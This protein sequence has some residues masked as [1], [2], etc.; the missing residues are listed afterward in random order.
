MKPEQFERLPL[1]ARQE[2]TKLRADLEYL[3][4]RMREMT[5]GDEVGR[6][7]LIYF[8]DVDGTQL[9]PSGTHVRFT[10]GEESPSDYVDVYLDRMDPRLLE[11]H[12]GRRFIIE[13]GSANMFGVR[14]MGF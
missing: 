11:V 8:P 12:G 6:V 10:L 7:R 13:P 9:L 1:H 14:T 2:I 4:K 5:P 3:Q